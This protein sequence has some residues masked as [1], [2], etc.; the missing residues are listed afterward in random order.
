MF[1]LATLKVTGKIAVGKGPDAI[2]YEP[3]TK[4]VFTFNAGTQD[5]T[6]IDAATGKVVGSIA[7]GGKPE[8]AQSDGRGKTLRQH[9]GQKRTGDP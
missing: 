1:D 5:A 4:R 6:A 3:F 8:F 2:L 9:R 7:L